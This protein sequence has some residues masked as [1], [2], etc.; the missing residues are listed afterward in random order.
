MLLLHPPLLSYT[1]NAYMQRGS[2]RSL[3]RTHTHTLCFLPPSCHGPPSASTDQVVPLQ[4]DKSCQQ[5]SIRER[6]L[7]VSVHS[8]DSDPLPPPG[9]RLGCF[10]RVEALE[11]LL[12]LLE[13]LFCLL[14]GR[15]DALQADFCV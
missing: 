10:V 2:L 9:W 5:R 13:V 11:H 4:P 14:D 7:L 12:R 8:T 1:K 15:L 3:A 6:T